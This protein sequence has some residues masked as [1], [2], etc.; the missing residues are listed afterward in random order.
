MALAFILPGFFALVCKSTVPNREK[1]RFLI[2]YLLVF[3]VSLGLYYAIFKS[4]LGH[5]HLEIVGRGKIGTDYLGKSRWFLKICIEASKLHLLLFKGFL[6]QYLFAFYVL[7]LLLRDVYKKRMFD[8]SLLLIFSVLSF[9]PHLVIA[10]SWGASRN[11]AL[12]SAVLVF[13]VCYRSWEILPVLQR[14][15]ASLL[16][17]PFLLLLCM[18]SYY[19]FVKPLQ[20]D[21][22]YLY[23]KVKQVPAVTDSISIAVTLPAFDMHENSSF[24]RRYYDEFNVSPFSF[25]WPVA[26][27]IKY[28]Y[29]ELHSENSIEQI[30][31]SIQVK[32]GV[33]TPESLKWDL[34]YK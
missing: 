24:L 7:F 28:F 11:F 8:L 1:K 31:R 29:Q 19:A 12:L 23:S 18:N 5:Y 34:N 30:D 4:M 20:E 22:A 9:F 2:N 21:Y 16:S 32:V 13:Y 6:L 3:F 10:E 27:A 17:I 26:P 33:Y 14:D 15:V 25:E